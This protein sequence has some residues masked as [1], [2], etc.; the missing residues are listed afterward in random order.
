MTAKW[1]MSAQNDP[2]TTPK[3]PQNDPARSVANFLWR[4]FGYLRVTLGYFRIALGLF[5]SHFGS[6]KVVF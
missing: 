4:H 5:W 6:I 3:S 2:K 1:P